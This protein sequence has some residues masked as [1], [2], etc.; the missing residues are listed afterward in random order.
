MIPMRNRKGKGLIKAIKRAQSFIKS[1]NEYY[2]KADIKKFFDNIDYEIL[3]GLIEKKIKDKR[4]MMLINT[5]IKND[6]K[7]NKG[8]PI[9]NLTSQ[10]FANIYLNELDHY[11]KEK[12]K[13]KFYLRYMDDFIIINE[14]IEKIKTSKLLIED[15]CKS[16]LKLKL[17]KE[18][19]FINKVDNG[20]PFCG[21]RI[22]KKIIRIKRESLNLS[23]I[24]IRNKIIKYE[25]NEISEEEISKSLNSIF[26]YWSKFD[27]LN[28]RKT[29][30]K[31]LNI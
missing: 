11:V 17:K 23:I 8:L 20:I 22:F 9:G 13:L 10:F 3:I 2:L 7:K 31:K 29:I 26:S 19:T 30:I 1:N 5:I 25:N 12:L 6:I 21:V 16:K 4:L 15:F 14:D 27:T 18:A 28:L 24:K